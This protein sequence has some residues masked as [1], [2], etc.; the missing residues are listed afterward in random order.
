M[1]RIN[2]SNFEK[3]KI[4]NIFKKFLSSNDIIQ[5]VYIL[6]NYLEKLGYANTA[7]LL[8]QFLAD[9][10]FYIFGKDN[11]QHIVG[12]FDDALLMDMILTGKDKKDI[13]HIL[14]KGKK[15][16]SK[17]MPK[18]VYGFDDFY[19]SYSKSDEAYDIL[20]ILNVSVCP[21]CN[22]QYTFTVRKNDIK[23]RPQFDHFFPKADYPILSISLYN[24]VPSCALCNNGKKDASPDNL[25]YPYEKSF[26][27]YN[28]HFSVDEIVPYLLKFKKNIEILLEPYDYDEK[29]NAIIDEYYKYY[30][31][32]LLYEGHS[33]YVKEIIE[34]KV[35]FNDDALKMICASYPKGLITPQYL[36]QLIFG[37]YEIDDY[38]HHPLSKF[39]SDIF[40]Q[41]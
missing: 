27:S 5:K 23:S 9:D 26:E 4:R 33:D 17:G 18:E 30:K 10:L 11:L 41:L 25:I 14:K 24:L 34:K 3:H 40:K 35:I 38:I 21:Y 16:P 20:N 13:L 39:T 29:I 37:K 6:A 19:G 32:K 1:I 22:R 28:I 2:L 8:L 12:A 31:I 36:E 15:A 7:K